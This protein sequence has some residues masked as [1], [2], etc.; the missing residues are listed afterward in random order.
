MFCRPFL[1]NTGGF[2]WKMAFQNATGFDGDKS[3]E[4]LVLGMKVR[5]RVIGMVH[6]DIDAK[7]IGYDGHFFRFF[8]SLLGVTMLNPDDNTKASQPPK[9]LEQVRSRL[10]VKHYSIRTERTYV[11]WIKRFIW[12]HGKRHPKDMGAVEM[13]AFLSYLA[14]ERNVSAS[15]QNQAKSALLFLYKEVLGVELSWLENV[16]QAK[17]PKRLPLDA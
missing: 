11:D 15:T 5:R 8:F 4:T 3:L 13:E 17:A 7:K 16:V 9:L 2:D 14:V 1:N 6:A 12:F 10:R